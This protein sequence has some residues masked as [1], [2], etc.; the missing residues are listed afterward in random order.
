[1]CM[2]ANSSRCNAEKIKPLSFCPPPH[3]FLHPRGGSPNSGGAS[4]KRQPTRAARTREV[5][6]SPNG[7]A[8][9]APG[10][11][12][13]VNTPSAEQATARGRATDNTLHQRRAQRW[14]AGCEAL[15]T[16]SLRQPLLLYDTTLRPTA[17]RATWTDAR[18]TTKPR[19]QACARRA[20]QPAAVPTF[21]AAAPPRDGRGRA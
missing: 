8:P 20:P 12:G 11:G 3:T 9:C 18:S 7:G 13:M 10:S 21:S 15:P 2:A 6:T 16:R 19:Q 4:A 14:G 5:N 1:L 17:S